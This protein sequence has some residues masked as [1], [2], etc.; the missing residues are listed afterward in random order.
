MVAED[1]E[2]EQHYLVFSD[3]TRVPIPADAIGEAAKGVRSLT[4][5]TLSTE[6]V[7]AR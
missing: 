6:V 3:G 7:D 1:T 2:R 4:D 5:A